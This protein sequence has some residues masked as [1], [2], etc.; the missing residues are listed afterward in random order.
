MQCMYIYICIYIYIYIYILY[1]LYCVYV[2]IQGNKNIYILYILSNSV[3]RYLFRLR[4]LH[5]TS[6]TKNYII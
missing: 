5:K 6:T 4:Y 2:Y 1:S 3:R